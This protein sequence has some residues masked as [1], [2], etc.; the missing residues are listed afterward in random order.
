MNLKKARSLIIKVNHLYET[1]SETPNA[2][3]AI[4]RE[5]ML[6]YLRGLYEVFHEGGVQSTTEAEPIRP[7]KTT[8]PE[9]VVITPIPT[10]VEVQE[11]PKVEIKPIIKPVVKE[12]T[13]PKVEVKAP[14]KV[15][16][17]IPPKVET[18]P[19][20]RVED[21]I[22]PR[23][24]RKSPIHIQKEI[25]PIPTR[26]P[27]VVVKPQPKPEPK[28]IYAPP[29][30]VGKVDVGIYEELF[31][32]KVAV[33]LSEKLSATPIKDLKNSMGINERF[34]NI[35]ELFKG[36][37][38]AFNDTISLLNSLSD[39]NSAKAHIVTS[40]AP[41]YDWLD[42]RRKNLA[43]SFIKKIRRRYK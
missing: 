34:L 11:P 42:D 8:I 22:P 37:A 24:E 43:K 39:F 10:P 15:E 36:N 1:I 4:E 6:Q 19:P 41:Q 12:I 28:V 5:L 40:L 30:F 38:I 7:S 21:L 31:E 25:E 3:P 20:I 16:D 9:P 35:S 23:V 17:L 27:I 26:K 14:I 18:R 32:K 2:I 13:P 33:D 29:P